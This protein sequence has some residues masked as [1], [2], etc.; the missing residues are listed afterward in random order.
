VSWFYEK[1]RG[2]AK[3][4]SRREALQRL[5]GGVAGALLAPVGLPKPS[6]DPARKGRGGPDGNHDVD[7]PGTLVGLENPA[8]VQNASH[9]SAVSV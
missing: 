1:A 3:G 8:L 6:C 7:F 9:L 5:A 2:L 4:V